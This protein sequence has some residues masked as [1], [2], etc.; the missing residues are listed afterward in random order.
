LGEES[1]TINWWEVDLGA[2]EIEAMSA[3]VCQ[4]SITQ[5]VLT[6]EL[7][8]KLAARLDVPYVVACNNGASALLMALLAVGVGPGA[9]VIIP[10]VSFIATANAPLLLGA[11][12][13]VVDVETAR[14]VIDTTQIERA[15][16][17]N[18]KAII[19]VH[20]NG[21]I[22][23]MQQLDQIANRYNL[24]V[25]EDAA[26]ALY[27]RKQNLLAGTHSTMGCFSL[28]LTKL[29]ATG[30][31]GFV[32]TKD[33]EL[34]RRLRR[35][36]NNGAESLAENRF[37]SLGFN[38]R[39]VDVLAAMGLAQLKK[40]DRKIERLREVYRFYKRELAVFD[41]L[42][43][44]P[45]EEAVGELPLWI[46]V[47]CSRRDELIRKW[48]RE[49]IIAKPFP[50]ALHRSEHLQAAGS[51]P[52]SSRF[53]EQGSILPS[54]PDQSRHDLA[55]VIDALHRFGDEMETDRG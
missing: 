51:Y 4:R 42:E 6:A 26:Q 44:L 45:V 9:E 20:S 46:E 35:I 54:G 30:E 11:K 23:D 29:I 7:E 21:R 34:Y 43:L 14:P 8:D 16:T 3:A 19:P 17:S 41:L 27:S 55:R 47:L 33:E 18:T 31:G 49:N 13:K 48:A 40:V 38:F 24:L 28:G 5:G 32:V 1:K 22:A 10:D 37:A 50:P 36:R 52:H 15:I 2:D 53:A 25:I 39:L 12:V